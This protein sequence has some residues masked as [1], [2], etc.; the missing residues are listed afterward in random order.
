MASN[1]LARVN[2]DCLFAALGSFVNL[3]NRPEDLR[4]FKTQWPK[5]FPP[6]AYELGTENAWIDCMVCYE[7]WLRAIWRGDDRFSQGPYLDI[8]LGLEPDRLTVL[9]GGRES[10][11]PRARPLARWRAGELEYRP[12]CDFQQAV[13]LL[14]RAGWRAKRCARC[15]KYLIADKPAQRYCGTDCSSSAKILRSRD[16]WKHHGKDWRAGKRARR[17]LQRV[18]ARRRR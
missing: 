14:F 1:R 12:A 3:R 16:W 10:W 13:Y 4:K 7:R 6:E 18:R 5:F 11:L 2:Q 9:P 15:R 8:L 17:K